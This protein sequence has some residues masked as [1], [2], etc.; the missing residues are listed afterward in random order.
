LVSLAAIAAE[1]AQQQNTPK[2]SCANLDDP[3]AII[4]DVFSACLGDTF[5]AMDRPKVPIKHEY[6]KPYF[7]ALQEAFFA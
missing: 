7:V 3:P 1:Q 5:H 2:M 6:K 4:V